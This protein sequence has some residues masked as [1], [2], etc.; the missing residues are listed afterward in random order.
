MSNVD[1][2]R[3]NLNLMD[4]LETDFEI[5]S[6]I[7]STTDKIVSYIVCVN[8]REDRWIEEVL[9]KYSPTMFVYSTDDFDTSKLQRKYQG[10]SD[11]IFYR[12]TVKNFELDKFGEFL[13]KFQIK[14]ID[15]LKLNIPNLDKS[16]I[17]N[18][19][20]VCFYKY[21]QVDLNDDVPTLLEG[22]TNR[23]VL[24]R[25][26]A[27]WEKD[28][29]EIHIRDGNFFSEQYP[30]RPNKY[31]Q[32]IWDR[33]PVDSDIT[34]FTDNHIIE[35]E[36][37]RSRVK[38]AW[39]IEPPIINSFIYEYVTKHP[40][41]FDAVFTFDEGLLKIGPKFKFVP[42]GTTWIHDPGKQVYSKTK[43]VSAIFS[44]KNFTT[45][46]SIRHEIFKNYQDIV[47]FYGSINGKRIE[48]KVEGLKDYAFSVVVE[49]WNGNNYF[50]EK[51]M[52]CLMTGTVPIYW[53]LPDYSR[54]FN[55]DGFL[56]FTNLEEFDKIINSLSLELYMDMLD[57]VKDNFRR[58]FNFIDLEENL[59]IN[60]LKDIING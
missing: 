20:N 11:I 24:P 34:V 1:I 17:D 4:T 47:N 3:K 28:M 9:H 6:G 12:D 27:L 51:L 29:K 22:H 42:Y 13:T 19:K 16:I 52:D 36:S 46:H 33:Q 25:I 53:G 49:N 56:Y 23:Y 32:W 5:R 8:P 55:A 44:S 30:E 15:V 26:N 2:V 7:K 50:S 41:A 21:L 43:L 10:F 60:G 58:A 48:H 31:F 57:A 54:F 45:G 39:L 18:L 40:N 37:S 59:W 35:V 14:S 38:V